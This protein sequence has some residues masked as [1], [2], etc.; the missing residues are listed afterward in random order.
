MH[1]KNLAADIA[2]PG[3]S[4]IATAN[5]AAQSG[6][7]GGIGWYEEG[8]RG[9]GGEGPHVH[10]D[11]RK[12]VARWGFEASGYEWHGKFPGDPAKLNPSKCGCE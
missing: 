9:S 7:F 2:V 12:Y 1:V 3:Q 11:L 5:Q 6:L 10:V 8:Y 4:N